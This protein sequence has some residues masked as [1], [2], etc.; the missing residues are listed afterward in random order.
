MVADVVKLKVLLIDD[1]P[2]MHAL[3]NPVS[4][5]ALSPKQGLTIKQNLQP[6]AWQR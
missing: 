3:Y 1:D 5:K 2:I 6:E 4:G